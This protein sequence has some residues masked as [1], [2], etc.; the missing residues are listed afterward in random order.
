MQAPKI[1]ESGLR[2]RESTTLRSE[3]NSRGGRA[4]E[5]GDRCEVHR[6]DAA[7][8]F[9]L[10]E[11]GAVSVRPLAALLAAVAVSA[12]AVAAPP[13]LSLRISQKRLRKTSK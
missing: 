5:R 9:E 2:R 7:Q 12:S 10:L 3:R 8:A 11:K 6:L 1:T 4:H 13:E